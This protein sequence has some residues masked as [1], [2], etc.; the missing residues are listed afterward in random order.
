M[1]LDPSHRI[2]DDEARERRRAEDRSREARRLWQRERGRVKRRLMLPLLVGVFL[3]ASVPVSIVGQVVDAPLVSVAATVACL[4]VAIALLRL[5]FDSPVWTRGPVGEPRGAAWLEPLL[6]HGF[7]VFLERTIPPVVSE[8]VPSVPQIDIDGLAIG[9]S[10]VYLIEPTSW[11]GN[12]VV[13]NG[14][15]LVGDHDRT[16]EVET[17]R[18][19]ALIAA[20]VLD[21]GLL[22]RIAVTPVVCVETGTAGMMAAWGVHIT[23]GS[24]LGR[25]LMDRP[26]VFDGETVVGIA[27]LADRRFPFRDPWTP[28]A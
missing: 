28:R 25:L 23:D 26:E 5:P 7:A 9:P 24:A 19:K 11:R 13:R 15:L 8:L 21:E 2:E 27:G 10:G 4:G 14:R 22:Q 20:T 12:A 3:V 18:D 17:V 6:D 1:T 16:A